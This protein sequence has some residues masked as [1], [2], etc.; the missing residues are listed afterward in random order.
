MEKAYD[1]K[2]LEAKLK[3]KGMPVLEGAALAVV[4]SVFEWIEESAKVSET[5]VDDVMAG[6]LPSVKDWV[7]AK[8][9]E[10]SE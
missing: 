6:L 4:D 8:V 9:D 1:L 7:H 5:K 2:V 3:E 10:I